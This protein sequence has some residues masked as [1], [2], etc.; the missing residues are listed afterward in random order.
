MRLLDAVRRLMRFAVALQRADAVLVFVADGLSLV[1]KGLMCLLA[2]VAGRGAIARFGSGHLVQSCKSSAPLRWW[3]RLTLGCCHRVCSQGTFWT[4]YFEQ[5]GANR[6]KVVEVRNGIDL[7]QWPLTDGAD[8]RRILF[9]GSVQREKG[10]FELLDAF[11]TLHKLYPDCILAIIGHGRDFESLRT[12][13]EALGLEGAVVSQGWMPHDQVS[14]AMRSS[15][16]LVLPSY[17]EGL[18]N[19]ILEAMA[20]GLPVIATPVGSIPEIVI[21]EETGELV[22]VQ[23]AGAIAA[24][25][26]RLFADPHRARRMG[27]AGRAVIENRYGIDRIWP[28]YAAAVNDA[29]HLSGRSVCIEEARR[30][31]PVVSDEASSIH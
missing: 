28:V 21:H 25:L 30:A 29:C 15:A 1:E 3:L 22:G 27:Q 7:R 24:A 16:V 10:V 20:S 13:I 8:G 18:P 26:A 4:S 6:S 19:V 17:A 23:D 12:R 5:S 14:L 9:V 2:R 11:D 31:H